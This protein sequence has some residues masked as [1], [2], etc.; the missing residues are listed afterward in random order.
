MLLVSWNVAGR[1]G[2]FDEQVARLL[3]LDADILC[4]QETTPRTLPWWRERLLQTGYHVCSADPPEEIVRRPLTVLTASRTPVRPS[5]V[6]AVPWPERVLA[7][8]HAEELEVVNVHSPISAKPDRAK[9]RTHMAV[10]RHLALRAAHPRLL[11]GDLNTP[12]R[13]HADGTVWTFARDKHG[14]LRPDR[15][16][17]W[18]QAELALLRG[19]E[20]FGFRDAF[21][22]LHGYAQREISWGWQR[23]KGGYRLDHLLVCGVHV[24][25]CGYEHAWRTNG[26]SDHS[27]LM[28]HISHRAVSRVS[29]TSGGVGGH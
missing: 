13:E 28:A 1:V 27:P 2:T 10:Y 12:R 24:H 3:E 25:E 21:R 5:E 26:L 22:E 8:L 29:G 9:I 19:L 11:C 16:E 18:D 17:D 14:R 4:L 6:S 7:T 20:P 23:W 15:G